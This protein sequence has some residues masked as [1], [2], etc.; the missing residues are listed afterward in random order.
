MHYWIR[1]LIIPKPTP[2]SEGNLEKEN[3]STDVSDG[4]KEKAKPQMS[5]QLHESSLHSREN[6]DETST[7]VHQTDA[8]R[9]RRKLRK[10][11]RRSK[12]MEQLRAQ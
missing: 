12:L 10:K 7:S 5:N 6:R 2:E 1:G 4:Y 3:S 11:R 8:R 9:R